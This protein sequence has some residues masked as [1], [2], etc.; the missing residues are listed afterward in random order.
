VEKMYQL[1]DDGF[2]VNLTL[3]LHAPTDE[4]RQKLMPIARKYSIKEIIKACDYYFNKTNRRLYFEYT[5][6]AGI[7]DSKECAEKLSELLKGKVCH[8]NVISLHSVDER[9]LKS[10]T[11]KQ[12]YKFVKYLE[13]NNISATLRRS[14]GEDIDGACGQLRKR[15]MEE[16]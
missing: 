16:I 8:V 1:A 3:S 10:T 4:I 9:E 15:V 7:N 14:L 12:G 11:K 13:D 6:C 5:L 2:K